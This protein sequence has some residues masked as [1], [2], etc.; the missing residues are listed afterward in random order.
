LSRR[1]ISVVA[2]SPIR[3]DARVLRQ[4]RCLAA[5]YEVSVVGYGELDSAHADGVRMYNVPLPEAFVARNLRDVPKLVLGRALPQVGYEHWYWDRRDHRAAFDALL[6]SRPELVLANDWDALPIAARVAEQTGAKIVLDLHEY[7][8]AQFNRRRAWMLL[9]S[10][11]ISYFLR[12]HA[13]RASAFMTVNQSIA[14]RYAADFGFTPSVVMNIPELH[15]TPPFRA[16]DPQRVRLVHHGIPTPDRRL[17]TMIEALA[18]CDARYELHLMLMDRNRAYVE[19]LRQLAER[20]APGRVRFD[21]AV[22]PGK[23]VET[24]AHFDLGI[25]ILEPHSYNAEVALPNTLFEFIAAGLAVCV[26]PSIEMARV[27]R[28][29]GCGI[30]TDSFEAAACAAALNR[31]GAEQIDE[32]KRGSLRAREELT[33]AVELAKLREIVGR[34]LAR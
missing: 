26:G 22:P 27:V 12:R 17:E 20:I 25:F 33:S 34:A 32:M 14:D 9:I 24:I 29:H 15:S 8:P 28:E 31:L 1:R 6:A 7:G 3:E 5:D 10:P 16:T 23:I 18:L 11:M 30:V 13:A 19:R 2:F 4:I 21:P